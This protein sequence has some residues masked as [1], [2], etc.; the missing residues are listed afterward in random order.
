[1]KK[2]I[3]L[4]ALT[5]LLSF[6]AS[7]YAQTAHIFGSGGKTYQ[8]DAMCHRVTFV[9]PGISNHEAINVVGQQVWCLI[10]RPDPFARCV[11]ALPVPDVPVARHDHGPTGPADW[12]NVDDLYAYVTA[13][14]ACSKARLG[15]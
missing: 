7:A 6:G 1:M 9:P 10:R 4:C 11:K 12:T 5:A 15:A 14:G 8:F 2:I 3:L 13:V